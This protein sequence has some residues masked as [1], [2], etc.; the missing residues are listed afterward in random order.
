MI[1]KFTWLFLLACMLM[2]TTQAQWNT[3]V[4]VN[5]LPFPPDSCCAVAPEI[6]Q[7]FRNQVAELRNQ[8]TDQMKKIRREN[9]VNGDQAKNAAIQQMASQYGLSDETVQNMKHGG[10]MSA[11]EKAA[12]A[13]KMLQQQ[14]NIS[15]AEIQNL[16]KLD[17]DGKKAWTQA[18]SAE[19]YAMASAGGN[20]STQTASLSVVQLAQNLQQLQAQVQQRR[21]NLQLRYQQIEM[22]PERIAA[23]QQITRFTSQITAMTGADGG[24]GPALDSVTALRRNASDQYCVTYTRAYR[25]VLDSQYADLQHSYS[26]YMHIAELNRLVANSQPVKINLPEGA[27][28]DYLNYIQEYIDRLAAVFQFRLN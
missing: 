1:R 12:L 2:G 18:Y 20:T 28:L 14:T 21:Q 9:K 15:M 27:D 16:K 7:A 5:A 3:Q 23:V 8:L 13:D 17:K 25:N 22:D 10:K 11:Q 6:R 19:A 4:F 24:Q 26:D